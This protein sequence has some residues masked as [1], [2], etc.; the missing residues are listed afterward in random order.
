MNHH[1]QA[2]KHPHPYPSAFKL[3]TVQCIPVNANNNSSSKRQRVSVCSHTSTHQHQGDHQQN[4]E[5]SISQRTGIT[6]KPTTGSS[7]CFSVH[8]PVQKKQKASL[9]SQQEQEQRERN[10]VDKYHHH[11]TD[12]TATLMNSN[13]ATE[14]QQEQVPCPSNFIYPSSFLNS[15]NNEDEQQHF[16]LIQQ[17]HKQGHSCDSHQTYQ[18]PQPSQEQPHQHQQPLFAI[19][20]MSSEDLSFNT[21]E[22]VP[23]LTGTGTVT[24]L[25]AAM[26]KRTRDTCFLPPLRQGNRLLDR[27]S[28]GDSIS[29]TKTMKQHRQSSHGEAIENTKNAIMSMTTCPALAHNRSNVNMHINSQE[30]ASASVLKVSSCPFL[31]S[32]GSMPLFDGGEQEPKPEEK[33]QEL[34]G[35]AVVLETTPAIEVAAESAANEDSTSEEDSQDDV[36]IIK[37]E[38]PNTEEEEAASAADFFVTPPSEIPDSMSPDEYLL[39]ILKGKMG[40]LD[41]KVKSALQMP[42]DFFPSPTQEQIQGYTMEMIDIVRE[43]QVELLRNKLTS[44]A[45]S[46]LQ[47]SNRFG[48]SLIHLAC[49]RGNK[50]TVH[51]LLGEA[52]VSA[53]C[54]D[55]VGRTPFHDCCWN[56]KPQTE[57]FEQLL[58]LDPVLMLICDKRNF[59]PFAYARREHWATWKAFLY[60]HLDLITPPKEMVQNLFT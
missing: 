48:E 5:D 4:K 1:P 24:T 12:I 59:T 50:E 18:Q 41:V 44:G 31:Q 53:R 26:T 28:S 40:G 17:Q 35:N 13:E 32:L 51:Y 56:P 34:S 47:L 36:E 60:E 46:S 42:A 14:Q 23:S 11:S 15:D 38:T 8:L 58:K 49:R 37:I 57:I 16:V 22:Q 52:N 2:A 9:I 29:T 21:L 30:V 7:S 10:Q 43:N 20:A 33:P 19:Q 3:V 45:V 25:E 6:A 54:R 39:L 27:I 55:D